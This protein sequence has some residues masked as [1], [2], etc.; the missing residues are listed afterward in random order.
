MLLPF[1]SSMNLSNAMAIADYDDTD[2][3]M[4]YA[5]DM[6]NNNFNFDKSQGNDF[7]KK[8]NC[9]NINSIINGEGNSINLG[10]PLGVEDEAI[11]HGEDL[12]NS[13]RYDERTGKG[14]FD[15]DCTNNNN[16]GATT[17][18]DS[19]EP[20]PE[21]PGPTETVQINS[22]NLY[23]IIGEIVTAENNIP[24]SSVATCDI[25][26]VV[27]EGGH[28]ILVKTGFPI[29][30]GEGPLPNPENLFPTFVGY[31]NTAYFT[32]VL[33]D[34]PSFAEFRTYAECLDNPPFHIP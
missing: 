34:S 1:G 20:G 7:I 32:T 10:S 13:Y 6:T 14:N 30:F 33:I 29:I 3:Y 17:P 22:T 4:K 21:E 2:R 12:P 28:E 15:V 23:R 5:E 31:N 19:E 18:H 26:D 16:N 24:T 9:N 25:G 8:I 27:F 11:Q